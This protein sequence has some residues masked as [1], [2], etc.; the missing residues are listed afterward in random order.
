MINCI[1]VV[2][3]DYKKFY[4]GT[5]Y[6]HVLGTVKAVSSSFVYSLVIAVD[7]L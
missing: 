6:C 2:R 5:L 3:I 1:P 4:A 7:I